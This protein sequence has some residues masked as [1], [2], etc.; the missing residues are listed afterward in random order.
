MSNSVSMTKSLEELN[1]VSDNIAEGVN[2]LGVT[3][4]H[5]CLPDGGTA[6]QVLKKTSNSVEWGDI[7]SGEAPVPIATDE[8]YGK[9]MHT[10]T[11][12]FANMDEWY[13]NENAVAM[14]P[15]ALL[16]WY[17][18]M[19]MD[20]S[21]HGLT[22]Y[23]PYDLNRN[24]YPDFISSDSVFEVVTPVSPPGILPAI[25][26]CRVKFTT[27]L[28]G[29]YP[30]DILEA[31]IMTLYPQAGKSVYVPQEWLDATDTPVEL[32]PKVT[33]GDS[34]FQDYGSAGTLKVY[35]QDGSMSANSNTHK[36]V[37]SRVFPYKSVGTNTDGFVTHG[38]PRLLVKHNSTAGTLEF[39]L[40]SHPSNGT[41]I[42]SSYIIESD[43][44]IPYTGKLV[45]L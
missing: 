21:A 8:Q 30:D 18:A 33:I 6:G 40:S 13:F 15:T 26:W 31:P 2:I 9:V 41:L 39:Y 23:D 29:Y 7:S 11:L 17:T 27:M 32:T 42:P 25:A 35:M 14:S 3:G 28:G 38:E 37:A 12:S 4:S 10:D 36:Y 24:Y 1:I 43:N 20:Y 19:R 22:P 16:N 45:K 44:W 34:T 5:N